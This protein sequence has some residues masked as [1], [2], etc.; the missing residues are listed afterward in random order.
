M[1]IIRKSSLRQIFIIAFTAVFA[2]SCA[3]RA[4]FRAYDT[5]LSEIRTEVRNI[6]VIA[7]QMKNEMITLKTSINIVGENVNKQAREIDAA[8]QHQQML[9]QAIDG[10][11]SS[12]VKLES[13]TIPE[14]QDELNQMKSS[15]DKGGITMIGK[16]EDGIIRVQTLKNPV[17]DVKNNKTRKYVSG[18]D[19]VTNGRTGFGYAVKD[20]VILWQTPSSDSEVQEIMIAWQQVTILGSL[21]RDGI[22]W[23]KVKTADFTGFVDSKSIIASD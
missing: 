1:Q 18:N 17:S 15:Q 14:K 8:K 19:I 13:E 22:N 7:D 5:Q 12:V 9:A 11:K 21:K 23:L 16:R 4:K 3:S 20:G 10:L 2:V 6:R